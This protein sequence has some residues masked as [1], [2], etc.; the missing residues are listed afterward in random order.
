[1]LLGEIAIVLVTD[2]ICFVPITASVIFPVVYGI[3]TK[4]V[5]GMVIMFVAAACIILRHRINLKRIRNGT[6]LHFSYL[7]DKDSEVERLKDN[8]KNIE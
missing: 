2:Y 1:M 8:I 5:L 4:D 3:M 6:E 7:W